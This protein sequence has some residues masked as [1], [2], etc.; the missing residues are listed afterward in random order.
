MKQPKN[1]VKKTIH[2]SVPAHDSALLSHPTRSPIGSR[3]CPF[4]ALGNPKCSYH[5]DENFQKLLLVHSICIATAL[6]YHSNVEAM[7]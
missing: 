2:N 6:H 1:F 7:Q 4:S 3:P 5:L